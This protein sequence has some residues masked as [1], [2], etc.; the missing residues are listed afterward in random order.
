MIS[1]LPVVHR[2][3]VFSGAAPF[4]DSPPTAVAV[5]VLSGKRPERPKNASLT[6]ELWNMT[7]SCWE[8]EPLRRPE[9]SEVVSQ[10]QRALIARQGHADVPGIT[11]DDTTQGN[12]LRSAS[13]NH[14]RTPSSITRRFRQARSNDSRHMVSRPE[15]DGFHGT[16]SDS[17]VGLRSGGHTE[18]TSSSLCGLLRRGTF[19]KQ[20]R[21]TP[22]AQS[23][24]DMSEK[25]WKMH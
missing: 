17:L 8:Q 7:Q 12:V 23:H 11:T 10:L 15:P 14:L 9:I 21:R 1:L 24:D 13:R 6:D 5:G 18:T 16:E 25:V 20:N 4:A 3:K 19:W 2:S 22:S